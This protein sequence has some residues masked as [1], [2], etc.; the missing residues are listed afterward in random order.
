MT[1]QTPTPEQIAQQLFNRAHS[2]YW[3][4]KD[5]PTSLSQG[6]ACIQHALSCAEQS[7]PDLANRLH[8]IA[9]S[10]AYNIA[11]FT[12][13]GWQEPGITITPADLASGRAAADL[14]LRLALELHRPP[15]P[16][17]SAHWLVGIHAMSVHDH[18]AAHH[19]FTQYR[20]IADTA[21]HRHLAD[22]YS[23]VNL[24]LS[25]P[26]PAATTS[27]NTAVSELTKLNTEDSNFFAAQLLTIKQFFLK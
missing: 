21:E 25:T 11:S 8:S 1:D 18:A 19:A 5:L 7:P 13:P 17:A 20:L 14:N 22:G 15:G 10:A 24:L 26:T 6:H 4:D 9:K 12:W 16:L 27:F 23:A 2:A 3:K